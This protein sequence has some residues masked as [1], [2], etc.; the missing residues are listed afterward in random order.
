MVANQT[1]TPTSRQTHRATIHRPPHYKEPVNMADY[2]Y[3]NL[4]DKP[5]YYTNSPTSD[6]FKYC[7]FCGAPIVLKLREL[8]EKQN[9]HNW[10]SWKRVLIGRWWEVFDVSDVNKKHA[11]KDQQ[12]E[13][14]ETLEQWTGV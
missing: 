4:E 8:W 14:Q 7:D 5:S 3:N 6:I 1:L 2:Y 9:P 10:L 11:C 13:Q 12:L